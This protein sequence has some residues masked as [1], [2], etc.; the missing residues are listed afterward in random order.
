MPLDPLQCEVQTK[1]TR[2]GMVHKV[3]VEAAVKLKIGDKLYN[4]PRNDEF[5]RCKKCRTKTLQVTEVPVTTSTPTLQ[6]FW[7]KPTNKE[8]DS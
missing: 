4:D 5:G 8:E 2:C 7:K 6:G 3:V 1:C